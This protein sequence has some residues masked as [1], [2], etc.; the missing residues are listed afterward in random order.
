M[1]LAALAVANDRYNAFWNDYRANFQ[2][3]AGKWLAWLLTTIGAGFLFGL[4]T[5]LP[6][7]RV[8]YR[9]SRLLLA[10]IPLV[11]IG[12]FWWLYIEQHGVQRGWL[13]LYRA[14]WLVNL[15]AQVGLAVLV[16]VAI[17]SGFRTASKRDD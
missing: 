8:R 3:G 1:S 13:W 5:W 2:M 14:D 10:A 12:Q 16:G 15:T 17:A 11:P 9:S 6:F 7:A 4:A